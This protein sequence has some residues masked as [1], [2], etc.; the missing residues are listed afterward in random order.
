MKIFIK[1]S[2]N[3]IV[4]GAMMLFAAS[5]DL[6]LQEK[7]EYVPEPFG[8]RPTGMTAYDW[9]LMI[10]GDTT[11]NDDDGLPQFQFMLDA[12]ERAGVFELYNNPD[13]Q[14][15]YFLLRNSAF[16][17]GGQ[18]IANMTGDSENPLDS[19]SPDRLAHALKYH[20]IDETMS[21]TDIPKNDFHLYYQSLIPGD[22]GVVEINKRLFNQE[23][24]IN[25]SIARV[26][27]GT[28][29][30][31]MP[32]SSKGATVVLH[33]FIFTNGIGHQ[34]NGYVRYQPF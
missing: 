20:I 26:G 16:N 29:P 28:T 2:I 18:L 17:G 23:I 15:T 21:Q 14:Q 31:T 13:A 24:R 12:I 8:N 3:I 9:M 4:V 34:L 30:T 22:T 19:I 32:S 6:A 27:G 33:N 11:Y 10:N 5:C 25:A 1:K 7:W